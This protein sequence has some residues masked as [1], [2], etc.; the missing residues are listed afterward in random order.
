MTVKT[1]CHSTGNASISDSGGLLAPG[2]S[3]DVLDVRMICPDA[4]VKDPHLHSGPSKALIPQLLCLKTGSHA[5]LREQQPPLGVL[6][7]PSICPGVL[8]IITGIA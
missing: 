4:G 6:R 1:L 8:G 7:Q 5:I 3:P 2:C